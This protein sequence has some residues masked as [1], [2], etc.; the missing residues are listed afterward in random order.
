MPMPDSAN[1]MGRIAG[2]GCGREQT[3][4][5]VGHEE[6]G[7]DAEGHAQGVKDVPGRR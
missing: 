6:R 5:N 7:E 2:S 1:E 4:G 3:H